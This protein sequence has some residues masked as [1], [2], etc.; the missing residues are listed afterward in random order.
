MAADAV[1]AILKK[2][3]TSNSA[4]DAYVIAGRLTLSKSHLPGD[5]ATALANFDRVPRLFPMSDAVPRSL[6]LAG[7]IRRDLAQVVFAPRARDARA[8]YDHRFAPA[9]RLWQA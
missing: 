7:E 4:P 6:A 9:L 2:Y 1:D 3:P 5:L 8:P